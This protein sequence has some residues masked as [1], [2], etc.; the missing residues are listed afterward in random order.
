MIITIIIFWQRI[1]KVIGI[2]KMYGL[3]GLNHR[4]LEKVCD[5]NRNI[6]HQIMLKP[7]KDAEGSTQLLFS[8]ILSNQAFKFLM[9]Y[10]SSTKLNQLF[11]SIL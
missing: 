1:A 7:R 11:Q 3:S 2:Q 5:V 8:L 6:V 9:Y 4:I 10:A